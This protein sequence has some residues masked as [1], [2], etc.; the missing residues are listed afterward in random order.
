MTLCY[1]TL[2]YAAKTLIFLWAHELHVCACVI[3]KTCHIMTMH[4]QFMR[5]NKV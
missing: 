3:V 4:D 2:L 5:T 1:T